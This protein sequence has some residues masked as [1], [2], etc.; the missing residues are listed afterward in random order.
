MKTSLLLDLSSRLFF[1]L[2]SMPGCMT[3][4]ALLGC[5]AVYDP[6]LGFDI[7]EI[8]RSAP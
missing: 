7:D 8:D 5:F 6:M 1:S 3:F 4:V 2:L